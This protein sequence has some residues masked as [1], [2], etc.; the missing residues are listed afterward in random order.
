MWPTVLKTKAHRSIDE[1]EGG[2]DTFMFQ[3]NAAADRE[4]KTAA[5]VDMASD[6]LQAEHAKQGKPAVSLLHKVINLLTLWPPMHDAIRRG[7]WEAP[8]K[9]VRAHARKKVFNT[10][11]SCVAR[12]CLNRRPR[13]FSSGDPK[14]PMFGLAEDRLVPILQLAS[15]PTMGMWLGGQAWRAAVR[16]LRASE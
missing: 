12:N 3:G 9:E 14:E 2:F 8:P 6:T 11:Y 1:V 4:A 16:S 5:E 7:L 15:I 10:Q 13:S